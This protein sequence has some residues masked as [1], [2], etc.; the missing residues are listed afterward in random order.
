[1]ERC[2]DRTGAVGAFE[3][4]KRRD[5][6]ASEPVDVAGTV[7]EDG[8][9]HIIEEAEAEEDQADLQGELGARDGEKAAFFPLHREP[10]RPGVG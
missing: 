2:R 1:M 8:A 6:R 3:G 9:V 4:S 7:G 5:G 10:N